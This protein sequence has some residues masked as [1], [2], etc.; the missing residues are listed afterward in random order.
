MATTYRFRRLREQA[1]GRG[2]IDTGRSILS[3]SKANPGQVKTDCNHGFSNGDKIVHTGLGAMDELEGVE[4]TITVVDDDEYTI[5]INTTTYGDYDGEGFARETSP[6]VSVHPVEWNAKGVCICT[7]P[8]QDEAAYAYNK[9]NGLLGY[10]LTYEELIADDPVSF[11]EEVEANGKPMSV[12]TG[13][14][15]DAAMYPIMADPGADW[16]TLEDAL[17]QYGIRSDLLNAIE[18]NEILMG[19]FYFDGKERVMF[20]KSTLQMA[21]IPPPT[22]PLACALAGDGAGN[23]EDGEH[24]YKV[25]FMDARGN[26]SAASAKS[27]PVDVADKGTDGKVALTAIP[28][29]AG[30]R[31]TS[32]LIYRTKADVDPD[33]GPYFLLT[34]ISDNTTTTYTD[35][36]ADGSL[37]AQL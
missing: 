10:G 21:T 16:Y 14:H 4:C 12:V 24:S 29:S 20:K 25:V 23:V 11:F 37:G 1:K 7:I 26:A 33:T 32:R 15:P 22:S 18:D 36:T 19:V 6:S 3:I 30:D 8:T 5:G 28:V 31:C 2:A 27:L 17:D 35:N 13:Y 9:A 34:T